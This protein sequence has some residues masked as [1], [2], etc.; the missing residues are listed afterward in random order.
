MTRIDEN[1]VK[2]ALDKKAAYGE[3]IDLNRYTEGD[4]E[5]EQIENITDTPEDLRKKMINVG[6]EADDEAKDGTILFIDNAMSHCSNKA[7]EGLIMMP[8][9]KALETYSWVKDYFWS[10]MDPAKDKYT[11][12]TYEEKADGYFVYVKPGYHLRMP[13]Q[14]GLA[15]LI[16]IEYRVLRDTIFLAESLL[17]QLISQHT[18]SPSLLMLE[19]Q[20]L[21][22]A[23]L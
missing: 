22:T 11:A 5:V 9:Q 23:L 14:R 8:V 2:K 16:I 7:Q 17:Q 3:D 13:V 21:L 10:A 18:E 19:F 4:Y 20:G 1:E 15:I 12:K 6:V